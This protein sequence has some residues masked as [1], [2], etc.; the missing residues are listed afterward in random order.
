[1]EDKDN[2][3]FEF[4]YESFKYMIFNEVNARAIISLL[5]DIR[6]HLENKDRKKIS[7]EL[8]AKTD[9]WLEEIKQEYNSHKPLDE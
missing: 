4:H 6:S 5:I 2:K 8:E 9:K 1:M 3:Q 7:D